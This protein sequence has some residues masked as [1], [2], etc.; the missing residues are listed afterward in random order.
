MKC[1]G[2]GRDEQQGRH[3]LDRVAPGRKGE[4]QQREVAISPAKPST[5]RRRGRRRSGS[6]NRARHS[7]QLAAVAIH[8]VVSRAS[9][10]GFHPRDDGPKSFDDMAG[11]DCSAQR[12]SL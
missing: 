5:N 8:K 6:A 9:V 7:G 12:P 2:G 11:R 3:G 10:S 1:T 4:Q